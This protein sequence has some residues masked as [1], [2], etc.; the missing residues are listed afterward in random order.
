MKLIS[1]LVVCILVM[2]CIDA[3]AQ[4]TFKT[5]YIGSSP[6]L[7]N[8][9]NRIGDS[10]GSALIYKGGINMPLSTKVDERKRPT[11]W[12]IGASASYTSFNNEKMPKDLI[13]SEMLGI[14]TVLYH[15]RPLNDKWY[16]MANIGLGMYTP[17]TKLSKIEYRNFLGN[18]GVIF[19]RKMKPN[20]EIGFGAAMNNTFGYPMLFPA[21]YFNWMYEGCLIFSLSMMDGGEMSV[22]YNINKQLSLSLVAEMSGQG[23]MLKENNREMMFSHQYIVMGFRPEFRVSK[24]I[25]ITLTVGASM[26]RSAGFDER[27]LKGIFSNTGTD[28]GFKDSFYISGGIKIGF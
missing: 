28:S 7:D 1:C 5:E 11:I 9:G 2:V 19:I 22:K 18:I 13:L 3:N 24:Y 14:Q 27:S 15:I 23:V 6:L 26:M 20:L 21:L 17:N 10:K 12:G 25:S 16:M 4:I 8:D